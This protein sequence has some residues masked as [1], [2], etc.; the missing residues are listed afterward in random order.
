MRYFV[1]D[2]GLRQVTRSEYYCLGDKEGSGSRDV[3]Y[4]INTH[5]DWSTKNLFINQNQ[6]VMYFQRSA[7][8]NLTCND[9]TINLSAQTCQLLLP[10]VAKGK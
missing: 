5:K 6:Y 8:I 10:I 1:Y 2:G 7:A 9:Y 3:I 4:H